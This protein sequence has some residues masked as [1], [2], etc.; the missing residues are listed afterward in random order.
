MHTGH[1]ARGVDI[2]GHES[3]MRDV[4]TYECQLERRGLG[5]DVADIARGTAHELRVFD[6]TDALSDERHEPMVAHR[7][8]AVGTGVVSRA[9]ADRREA[10]GESSLPRTR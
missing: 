1:L 6:T 2:Y 4:G 9:S 5:D 8:R 10:L 7:P 3:R